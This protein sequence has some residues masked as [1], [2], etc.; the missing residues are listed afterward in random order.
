[1]RKIG[2][3]LFL[4]FPG[5]LTL[6]AQSSHPQTPIPL[7]TDYREW[8]F[9]SAGLGM[10]YGPAASADQGNPK[11][12]NVFV[13]PAAYREF[14]A[15]G[16]WPDKTMFILEIR[17]ASEEGSINNAGHFQTDIV[18]VEAEVKDESR[19]AQPWTFYAFGTAA[20]GKAQPASSTCNSCHS[21]NGATDNTFVQFYPT[22]LPI[23]AKK[24]T[25]TPAYTKTS[26]R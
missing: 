15:T 12:D 6:A 20:E 17:K 10:T 23:A 5:I 16:K 24:G 11:F 25:L 14:I 18:A 4:A 22:L 1:M 26:T 8:I 7:P 13:K 2:K 19:P 21:A 9:L 3:I